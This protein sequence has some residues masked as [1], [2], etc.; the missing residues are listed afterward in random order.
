[1]KFYSLFALPALAAAS[2]FAVEPAVTP[3]PAGDQPV[4]LDPVTVTASPEKTPLAV[5]I[6]PRAASQP[7][8]AH[9]GADTLK[10]I[11]GMS[12]IRKGGIDGDPVFRGMAGSRLGVQL[13]GETILGGCGMRMD[14]PTAY[15]FPA[16][17]DR[18]T[19]RKGPQTVLAG[20]G[21]SAG[22]VQFESTQ[23]DYS[24]PAASVRGALTWGS[25]GRND[26]SIHAAAGAVP[27]YVRAGANHSSAGDYEDSDGR[28]V[29]SEYSRWNT[30]GALGWTPAPHLSIELSGARSDGE[31]A[32][33]D[34]AMDGVK[35]DRD[36]LGLR[37]RKTDIGEI[38]QS[39]D[40]QA[41]YNYVDHVMDNF[42]L[43]TFTPTM[44][45]PNPAVSNPDRETTGG[46]VAF[47][48]T[49]Q[50]ETSLT[51]G[52]DAQRNIHTL[53]STMNETLMPYAAMPRVKDAEFTQVG[54]FGEGTRELSPQRRLIAGVRVD[55][56]QA[57]KNVPDLSRDDTLP[58]GFVRYEHDLGGAT[59][60][61]GLGHAERFPDYWEI[62]G[63]SP[64]KP[65][66][67]FD[68]IDAEKTTQ[69]DVG[70]TYARGPVKAALSLFANQIDDFILSQPA[71]AQR[72]RNIDARTFGGEAGIDYAFAGGWTATGSLA[73]VRGT[74]ETDSLPLA[75]MPP[76]EARLGLSYGSGSW[77]AGGLLRM[78]ASQ[79]RVAP[80]QGNI[81]GQDI[82]PSD[83][84]VVVSLNAGYQLTSFAKVSAGIDNLFDETYAEHISRSG[85]AI[86]GYPVTTR[87]NEPGLNAW[88]KFDVAY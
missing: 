14:P 2:A 28:S 48:L 62:I 59:A 34:R 12:I 54:V 60:Y 3:T 84:F 9:D 36:N 81:V 68:L 15:V 78:V 67:T 8:P 71:L 61:L 70:V 19:L 51:L 16:S 35:F 53:R 41:Y 30:T 38:L 76:F 69:V 7:I 57:E 13:D 86:A 63:G 80:G 11:P 32:Y 50:A 49:P 64:A 79:N 5:V 1:M 65:D 44:M 29:H 43:R 18:V 21:N 24:R 23:P 45:M 31:A 82:G 75:Q 25:F 6:D 22:V 56:W 66:A 88:V 74:N 20:P 85:A 37:L 4:V 39:V 73:Y 52:A 40:A 27:G 58:G 33:A 72:T 42:S 10:T 26:Q 83:G 55:A 47:T 77:V 46:R 87:V 17:Y